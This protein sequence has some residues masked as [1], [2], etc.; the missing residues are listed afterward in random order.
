MMNHKILTSLC[1]SGRHIDGN[2]SL[3][4]VLLDKGH[5]L[6]FLIR[7]LKINLFVSEVEVEV[8]RK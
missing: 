4:V 2:D 6:V 7:G 3:F 5:F 1:T 8:G